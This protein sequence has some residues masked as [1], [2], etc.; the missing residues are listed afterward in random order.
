MRVFALAP[1]VRSI[2]AWGRANR[3]QPTSAAPGLD[4]AAPQS[5]AGAAYA[6][7]DRVP[8]QN[9][10]ISPP[11]RLLSS[12]GKLLSNGNQL[13]SRFRVITSRLIRKLI[14]KCDLQRQ[15]EKRDGSKSVIKIEALTSNSIP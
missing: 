11:V 14:W 7:V 8:L 2:P 9:T 1:T 15:K 13:L 12:R 3:R 10:V 5:P 4:R 6:L